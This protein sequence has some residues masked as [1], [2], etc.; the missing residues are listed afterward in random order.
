MRWRWSPD[1][2]R[3]NDFMPLVIGGLMLFVSLP[4]FVMLL[5]YPDQGAGALALLLLF[6]MGTG[7][8]IGTSLVV[9]GLRICSSPGSLVYRI[10]HG[11]VLRW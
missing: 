5:V 8:V 2:R 11:H 9:L 6:V 7:N 10:T 1:R 4:G 3:D